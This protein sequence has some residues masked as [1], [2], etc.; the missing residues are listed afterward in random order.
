MFARA[1]E[2]DVVLLLDEGDALMGRRTSVQSANDRY[3]NLETNYLLQRME[4]FE[5]VLVVTT[6]AVEHIDTAFQRRMDAVVEFRPPEFEERRA[7][8]ELHLPR[9]HR[10]DGAWLRE[11]ASRCQFSGGQIRNASQHAALLA[12]EEGEAL[13]TGHLEEAVL[14]EYRKA[15]SSCP[16]RRRGSA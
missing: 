11:V 9:E 15:K 12:M 7:I 4:S 1:E 6:N 16:L 2:T 5:G 8:W 10:V 14:R 3:A 13:H